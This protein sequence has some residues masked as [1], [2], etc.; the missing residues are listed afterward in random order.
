MKVTNHFLIVDQLREMEPI[1]NGVHEPVTVWVMGSRG[2]P[3]TLLSRHNIKMT[4][5]I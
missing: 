3:P 5:M 4:P 1:V 2:E